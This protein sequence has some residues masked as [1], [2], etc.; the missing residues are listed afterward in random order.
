[1]QRKTFA[2]IL[3][4]LFSFFMQFAVP[5]A[6]AQSVQ[7]A[8]DSVSA[9]QPPVGTDGAS[10]LP[11]P[12]QSILDAGKDASKSQ[13]V[14]VKVRHNRPEYPANGPV[15]QQLKNGETV[16]LVKQDIYV[17]DGNLIIE[18]RTGGLSFLEIITG[19]V[20]L[21][22]VM[23]LIGQAAIILFGSKKPMASRLLQSFFMLVCA[24]ALLSVIYYYGA[25]RSKRQWCEYSAASLSIVC[26]ESRWMGLWRQNS[27]VI[28][29]SKDRGGLFV[30]DLPR[31]RK[32]TAHAAVPEY[33]LFYSE[34]LGQDKIELTQDI[35]DY[36]AIFQIAQYVSELF[37]IRLYDSPLNTLNPARPKSG[38]SYRFNKLED[39]YVSPSARA[40]KK[41]QSQE[42]EN[43]PAVDVKPEANQSS[44]NRVQ[45]GKNSEQP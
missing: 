12:P 16:S 20:A 25:D 8:Q 1:M 31:P 35:A 38:K 30:K 42:G 29:I 21:L 15:Y 44:V 11:S 33:V 3:I 23:V 37:G 14:R 36:K 43:T 7:A 28:E 24:V 18:D 40:V 10:Q 39:D 34:N 22:L 2:Q 9:G 41:I 4:L 26:R 32:S 13:I 19:L 5:V 6:D 17:K 45:S 27:S